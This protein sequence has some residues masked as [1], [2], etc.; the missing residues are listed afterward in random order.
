[1]T[2]TGY[3]IDR[4]ADVATSRIHVRLGGALD[5]SSC[6]DLRRALSGSPARARRV[7]LVIDMNEVTSIG[8]ECIDVLLAGYTRALRT[9]QGYEIVN[10]HGAVRQALELSRLCIPD[11]TDQP[12]YVPPWTVPVDFAPLG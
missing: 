2:T 5:R 7:N 6:A 12:L 4:D 8:G 11:E 9:G 1:M 3:S 10:P